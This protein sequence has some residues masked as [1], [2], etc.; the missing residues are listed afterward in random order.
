MT[1]THCKF[2]MITGDKFD[3]RDFHN[4][5]LQLGPSPLSVVEEEIQSYI[6]S[7]KLPVTSSAIT[8]LLSCYITAAA[9]AAAATAASTLL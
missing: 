4:I 3:G 5:I 8:Q 7:R 2:V 1:V 6:S 9:A